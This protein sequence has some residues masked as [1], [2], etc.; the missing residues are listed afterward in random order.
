M[1]Q[2]IIITLLLFSMSAAYA[3]SQML[4]HVYFDTD[5]GNTPSNCDGTIDASE[6]CPL[7]MLN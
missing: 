4:L 5:A 1:K 2:I 7:P 3:G 6:G